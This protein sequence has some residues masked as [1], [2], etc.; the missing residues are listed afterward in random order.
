MS[1]DRRPAFATAFCALMRPPANKLCENES[2]R[3]YW[4]LAPKPRLPKEE[5]GF[6][7]RA[8]R[9]ASSSPAS[10]SSFVAVA[11]RRY[12]SHGLGGIDCRRTAPNVREL[13][14]K[15]ARI[16]RRAVDLRKVLAAGLVLLAVGALHSS[17]R[18]ADRFALQLGDANCFVECESTGRA[19]RADSG[20]RGG[21]NSLGATSNRREQTRGHK[22]HFHQ[23]AE[24]MGTALRF[25]GRHSSG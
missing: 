8:Q 13:G 2:P 1:A 14:G 10:L 9:D 20:K 4:F 23:C 12:W 19:G 3:L 7:P 25:S 16:A 6:C 24:P 21:R 18:D 15:R 22:R 11:S 17:T 5:N